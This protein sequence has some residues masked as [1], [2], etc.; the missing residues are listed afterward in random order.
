LRGK[1]VRSLCPQVLNE[2]IIM[3]KNLLKELSVEE[4]KQ[5]QEQVKKEISKRT[6]KIVE[7]E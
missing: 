1:G 7:Q 5:L 6:I 2:R 4:L 3:D